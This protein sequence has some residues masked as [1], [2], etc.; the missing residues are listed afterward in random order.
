MLS[1][2]GAGPEDTDGLINYPRSIRGIE[3]ALFFRQ[4]G[5]GVFKV[6]FRSKGKVDVGSLAR[7]LGGGGHHNAAGATVSGEMGQVR[8]HVLKRLNELLPFA[9]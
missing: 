3:V 9:E 1:A 2:A 5:S 8:Q 6:S 4:E 7:E